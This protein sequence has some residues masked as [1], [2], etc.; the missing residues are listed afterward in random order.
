MLS[1][2]QFELV[3]NHAW[4]TS[5]EFTNMVAVSQVTPGPIGINCATYAGYLAA[6]NVCGAAVATFALVLPSFI[7][8]MILARVMSRFGTNPWVV[9][10]M[11]VLRPVVVGLIAAAALLL[12][13]PETFG[14]RYADISAWV[15]F[16][17]AFVSVKWLRVSAIQMLLAA[18]VI[19]L[20]IY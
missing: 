6:D 15:I 9:A 8:M 11:S 19:G 20:I 3:E 7:I 1:L 4:L 16:I 17:A 14:E 5:T 18:A 2:I 10:V 12:I 13:T